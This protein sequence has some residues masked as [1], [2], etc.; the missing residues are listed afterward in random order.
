MQ[1]TGMPSNKIKTC[2]VLLK[3]DSK[4]GKSV[5][6]V[7]VSSGPKAIEKANKVVKGMLKGMRTGF[8][9]KN[10]MSC[11]FCEFANTAHCT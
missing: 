1:V 6:L 4:P 2:F 9:I 11:K 7:E 8:S 10:R 5:A 3:R